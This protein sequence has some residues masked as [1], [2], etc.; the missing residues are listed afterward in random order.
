MGVADLGHMIG[1]LGVRGQERG[2]SQEVTIVQG[3]VIENREVVKGQGPKVAPK[4]H[5]Q[6]Q[7]VVDALGQVIIIHHPEGGTKSQG[8]DHVIVRG[9]VIEGEDNKII[10]K[11]TNALL[12]VHW[13]FLSLFVISTFSFSLKDCRFPHFLSMC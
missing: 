9:L 2:R 11:Q 4:G 10:S 3:H 5:G 12:F 6:G 13:H 7:E 8:L 1:G